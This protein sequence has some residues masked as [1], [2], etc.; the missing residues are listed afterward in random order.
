MPEKKEMMTPDELRNLLEQIFPNFSHEWEDDEQSESLHHVMFVFTPFFG[1]QAGH[2][3][4]KQLE[5][6]A[7]FINRSVQ[8]D[9]KLENAISTCFLEHLHQINAERLLKPY[10]TDTAKRKLRA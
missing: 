5:Q 7:K 9:D 2:A 1:G 8:N 4:P 3:Q 10:L 6:L